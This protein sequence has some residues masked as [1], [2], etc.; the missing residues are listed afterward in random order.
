M[1]QDDIII[2]YNYLWDIVSTPNPKLFPNFIKANE[3]LK[4]WLTLHG[5]AY[6]S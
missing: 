3:T 4:R 1:D 5:N 2:D 6:I